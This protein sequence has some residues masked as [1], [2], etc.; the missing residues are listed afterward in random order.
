MND[1]HD[2][3]SRTIEACY[4]TGHLC[5][6]EE[7]RKQIVRLIETCDERLQPLSEKE[8]TAVLCEID[9]YIASEVELYD[10]RKNALYEKA[11]DKIKTN[12]PEWFC[13]D[14]DGAIDKVHLRKQSDIMNPILFY[15]D[16][17]YVRRI[18]EG[19]DKIIVDAVTSTFYGEGL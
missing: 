1:Y 9:A 3:L 11:M 2:E 8:K 18:E 17:K 13:P 7:E 10:E 19:I 14:S 15:N 4:G 16:K 12:H 5:L 6:Y